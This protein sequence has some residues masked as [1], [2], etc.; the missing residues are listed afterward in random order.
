MQLSIC[1]GISAHNKKSCH[2]SNFN[3]DNWSDSQTT[4]H[5]NINH[6]DLE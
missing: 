5:L 1:T 2:H 4:D 3:L 6:T